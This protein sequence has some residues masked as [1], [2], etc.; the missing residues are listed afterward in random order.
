MTIL[1]DLLPLP[2][3]A[4]APL[5]LADAPLSLAEI[6]GALSHALDLTSGQAMGHAQRTCLIGMRLGRE[7]GLPPAQL[8]SLYYALLMK[9]AGC[10]SNAARMFE[11]FGSDDIEAKR[12]GKIVDWS[13]LV[14][15]LKYAAH[16]TLPESPLLARARRMLSIAAN[17][18]AVNQSFMHSRCS[19]GAQIA[20]AIGLANEAA[21]CI[22]ALDEHWDGQGQP[23]HTQGDQ[24]PVLARIACIAQTMEVFS[25][26]FGLGAAYEVVRARSRRWFDPQLVQAAHAF[27]QDDAFWQGV[28]NNARGELRQLDM[29]TGTRAASPS[30]ID[31]VC[32]AFAQIVDAKSPFTGEHSS[33]VAHYAVEIA[34]S[35]GFDTLRTQQMRRAG[36]LHDV[37]KLAVSNAILDKPGPLSDDEWAI[38]RRHPYHSQQIL[39]QIRGFERLTQIAAA[40]HERLDGRG[41]FQGLGAADLDLDMRVLA[42]AD[43]FDALSAHRPYRDAMPMSKVFG[44]LDKDAGVALDADCIAALKSRYGDLELMPASVF[45]PIASALSPAPPPPE[46]DDGLRPLRA[47]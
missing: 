3:L 30:S 23:Y 26:T 31:S 44:I 6:L 13:N 12:A 46:A 27:R 38:V 42:C 22:R 17:P 39:G 24:I 47:A 19:R 29:S 34:Q 32:N 7:I 36:L 10:S 14:E 40:H 5:S 33:R 11:I 45:A 2:H 43:V 25:T 41:Y 1:A 8:S 18:N 37:G 20:L 4:D 9:D 16:H 35:L 28:Q 15:A 21:E